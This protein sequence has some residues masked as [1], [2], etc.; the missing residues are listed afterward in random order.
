MTA[1][2]MEKV[3]RLDDRRVRASAGS[4]LAYIAY[5]AYYEDGRCAWPSIETIAAACFIDER[6]VRRAIDQLIELDYLRVSEDQS[7]NVRDAETGQLKPS[8]D[9]TGNGAVPG[10]GR[11]LWMCRI[12]DL[13]KCPVLR[14]GPIRVRTICPRRPVKMSTN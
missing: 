7:W 2:T 3:Y 13:S 9:A 6:T 8:A 12:R 4:V 1:A 5:R 11:V 10:S 14:M